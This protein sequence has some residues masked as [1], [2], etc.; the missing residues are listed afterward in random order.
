M[1]ENKTMDV[2]EKPKRKYNRKPKLE[3]I[4]EEEKQETPSPPPVSPVS[5]KKEL[6]LK[7]AKKSLRGTSDYNLF[8]SSESKNPDYKGMPPKERMIAIA[9]KWQSMKS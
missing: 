4:M 3:T 1:T 2:V 8:M 7:Q 9:A 5:P 6:V